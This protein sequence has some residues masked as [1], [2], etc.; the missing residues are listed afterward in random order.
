L[1]AFVVSR[2]VRG[3]GF[4]FKLPQSIMWGTPI[5]GRPKRHEPVIGRLNLAYVGEGVECLSCG[6]I[7]TLQ[8]HHTGCLSCGRSLVDRWGGRTYRLAPSNPWFTSFE[9]PPAPPRPRRRLNRNPNNTA[10]HVSSTF[11][12]NTSNT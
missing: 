10:T 12:T 2:I 9:V 4:D 11:T 5:K 7:W 3:Q 6:R 1:K 8:R